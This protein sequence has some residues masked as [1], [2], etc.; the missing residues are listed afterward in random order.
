MKVKKTV[1]IIILLILVVAMCYIS[2][3]GIYKE[4]DGSKVNIIPDYNLGMEFTETYDLIANIKE[5]STYNQAEYENVKTIIK[6]RLKKLGVGQYSIFSNKDTGELKIQVK[7]DENLLYTLVNVMQRGE[8]TIVDSEDETLVLLNNEDLK[9]AKATYAQAEVGEITLYLQLEFNKDGAKKLEDISKEYVETEV[10]QTNEEGETEIVKTT[11]NVSVKIDGTTYSTT[12]FGEPMTNG[13]LY[14]PLYS[15]ENS[16][17]LQ[18]AMESLNGI[19]VIL[20]NGILPDTYEFSME[21]SSP[22]ISNQEL[23][24]YCIAISIIFILAIIYL[25]IKFKKTGILVS[26]VQIG[27]VALL[28]LIIR[29]TNVVMTITG[30]MGLVLSIVFNYLMLYMILENLE[31]KKSIKSSILKFFK[32]T[33]PVYIAAIVLTFVPNDSINSVGMTL[34]WG[35]VTIYVFNF[36][37]TKTILEL[38]EKK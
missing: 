4:V 15:V 11:K 20:N 38:Q 21:T 17:D 27:Y 28:L 31:K 1:G 30:M 5:D 32:V 9:V 18:I 13:I 35:S 16:D 36:I 12:Y 7:Q 22:M 6:K 29:Y 3:I 25:I 37:F 10:E 8:L 34:F 14:I 19:A 23:K 33:I 24:I 2:F 26:L